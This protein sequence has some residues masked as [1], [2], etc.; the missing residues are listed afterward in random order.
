MT[1]NDNFSPQHYLDISSDIENSV[2]TDTSIHLTNKAAWLRCAG[3][4]AYYSAFLSLR[5]EFEKKSHLSNLLHYKGHDHQTIIEKLNT[6]TGSMRR[7]GSI[8][9]NLR[10][11]RQGCDYK[12]HPGFSVNVRIIENANYNARLLINDSYNIVNSIPR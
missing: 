5:S 8:L 7:Y 12:L 2:K 3:S 9:F 4:R 10:K 6:L 11:T 1:F